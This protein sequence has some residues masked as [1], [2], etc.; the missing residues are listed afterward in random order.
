MK[1]FIN[2]K[3]F[4]VILVVL[5]IIGGTL[6]F[7]YANLKNKSFQAKKALYG[8]EGELKRV[9]AQRKKLSYENKQ[10]QAKA[11]SCLESVQKLQE[12]NTN[13]SLKLKTRQDETDAYSREKENFEEEKKMF[14]QGLKQLRV[15]LRQKEKEIQQLEK[16]IKSEKRKAI[17]KLSLKNS[18]LNNTI[19]ELKKAAREK[20]KGPGKR[21]KIISKLEKKISKAREEAKGLEEKLKENTS[22]I[23]GL[24]A[25]LKEFKK[26]LELKEDE[27]SAIERRAE[28][29][30]IKLIWRLKKINRKNLLLEKKND[31]LEEKMEIL[32]ETGRKENAGLY[33]KLGTALTQAKSFDRAIEA[34]EKSLAFDAN[35]AGVHYNLGLLYEHAREDS[36]KAVSHL[37]KYLRLS[38][39]AENK[40]FV[41]YL[42]GTMK[43]E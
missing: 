32:K 18:R 29:D 30:R 35:N 22:L 1:N 12:E 14:E 8:L 36:K 37:R 28:K 7:Q 20:E 6:S 26:Q 3:S 17:R 33:E 21:Q 31:L 11:I 9:K 4:T 43:K 15:E 24:E 42:I 25:E 2:R 23:S 40:T 10:L 27:L 5:L 19:R 34:Y 39:D 41:E 13:L 38:P 16:K